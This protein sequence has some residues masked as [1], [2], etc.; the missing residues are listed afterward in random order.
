MMHVVEASQFTNV[1]RTLQM[2]SVEIIEA[3][4]MVFQDNLWLRFLNFNAS[5]MTSSR[6]AC[7]IHQHQY[8]VI[9]IPEIS[10]GSNDEQLLPGK[11]SHK[12]ILKISWFFMELGSKIEIQN[13]SSLVG[14]KVSFSRSLRLPELYNFVNIVG[15]SRLL[16]LSLEETNWSTVHYKKFICNSSN[17]RRRTLPGFQSPSAFWIFQRY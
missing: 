16:E 9:K 14:A 8:T 6:Q 12:D 5:V 17:T 10:V 13:W 15:W 3:L 4:P 2:V 11:T 1:Q 7:C